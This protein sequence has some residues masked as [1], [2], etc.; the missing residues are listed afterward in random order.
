[1]S[2]KEIHETLLQ[3]EQDILE[4]I[5]EAEQ[6]E[7]KQIPGSLRI[8]SIKG[9]ARYYHKYTDEK[10]KK[11]THYISRG[12]N[13]EMITSLAQYSYNKAFLKTAYRQLEAVRSALKNIDEDSLANVFLH[14][15]NERKNLITPYVPDDDLFV[16]NWVDDS[17][18]PGN[19]SDKDPEIY[20]ENGERVRSKSEKILADKYKMMGIR[21][22]YEKP[23]YL[24]D[25]TQFVT[26]RPDF[27]T[28]NVRKRRQYYHEHLGKMDDPKYVRRNIYKLKLY[29]K[30]GIL[31]GDQLFL[32]FESSDQPLDMNHFELLVKHYLL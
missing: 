8:S 12:K 4:I 31:I 30:N 28:L 29:E 26:M 11:H 5:R 9:K 21:Y 23:L 16:R 15:H 14:L 7:G 1:M 19:F 17:Y 27:T 25:R 32:T 13:A 6:Y 10:G 3:L 24:I 18:P 2:K 20:S 22:K